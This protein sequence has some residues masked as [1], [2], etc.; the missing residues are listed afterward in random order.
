MKYVIKPSL[1]E[2]EWIVKIY[3]DDG[4]GDLYVATFSGRRA[5]TRAFEYASWQ[6][7]KNSAPNAA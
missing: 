2:N 1:F 6:H 3:D 4:D 7:T 5:I